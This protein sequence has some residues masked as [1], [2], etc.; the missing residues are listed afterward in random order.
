MT[1]P[2]GDSGT[3]IVAAAVPSVRER[4]WQATSMQDVRLRAG[5][6]NG[7]LFHHFSTRRDRK[8]PVVVAALS[9]RQ[10]VVLT[11]LEQ[12]SSARDLACNVVLGHL[13]RMGGDRR[14]PMLWLGA[15]PARCSTC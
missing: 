6:S 2:G 12:A 11:E 8:A 9:E 3:V 5:V 14:M 1:T 7:S 10:A 15:L 4:G 13:A